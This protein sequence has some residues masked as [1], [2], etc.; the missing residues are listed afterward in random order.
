MTAAGPVIVTLTPN[1]ALDLTYQVPELV[2]GTTHR[3]A[4]RAQAGGKGVNVARTLHALGHP[5]VA[6]LPLGGPDGASVGRELA[7]AGIPARTVPIAEPTRRTVTVVETRPD[8]AATAFNE[9]GPELGAREWEAVVAEVEAQLA[10]AAVLVLSGRLPRGVPE[11]AYARLVAAANARGVPTVLDAEGPAL[12]A[13][14][15]AGPSVVKPNIHELTAATG[16]ADPRRAA[17]SLREAGAGAVVVSCGP[18]GL[19]AVTA[20]GAWSAR[21]PYVGAGNPTGAGDAA[22]AA[23]ALGLAGGTPWPEILR[24]AAALSAATVLTESAGFFDASAFRRFP[25]EVV[26]APSPDGHG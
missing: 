24:T 17:E 22:V 20:E 3:P 25:G 12:L 5:V 26:V 14:V 8:G 6:V 11:H 19:L 23:L 15:A 2:P 16:V 13:G 7:A 10:A 4:V 18:D 21:P 9:A 1:P